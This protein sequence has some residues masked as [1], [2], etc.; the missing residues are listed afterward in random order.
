MRL[1]LPADGR[2]TAAAAREI[3]TLAARALQGEQARIAR[4]T[5]SLPADG[6]VGRATT[7]ALRAHQRGADG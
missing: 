5:V 4:L 2:D 6:D 3:A 1:R 7:E